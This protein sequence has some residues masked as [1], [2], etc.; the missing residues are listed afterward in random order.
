MQEECASQLLGLVSA[1]QAGLPTLIN[2]CTSAHAG[3][4]KG[5]QLNTFQ[6]AWRRG[7]G[8]NRPSGAPHK[9]LV[10]QTDAASGSGQT[11]R[12]L[13]SCANLK[14]SKSLD[15]YETETKRLVAGAGDRLIDW[16][17][18]TASSH[19]AQTRQHRSRF[20][21]NQPPFKSLTVSAAGA[22]VKLLRQKKVTK[23]LFQCSY[24]VCV[25]V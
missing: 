18:D 7:F 16:L 19:F 2:H 10:H 25:C 1:Q 13:D 4:R 20:K 15:A 5:S 8:S 17:I 21:G 24:L 14:S 12:R 3:P 9:L 23:S 11:G 6:P 22:S